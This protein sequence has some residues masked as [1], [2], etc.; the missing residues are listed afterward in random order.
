MNNNLEPLYIYF[1]IPKTGGTTFSWTVGH[2]LHRENDR[3]LKHYSYMDSQNFIHHNIPLL[4]RRT[5]EQQR[6]LKIITG[7]STFSM[8][9]YWLKTRRL[10]RY[11][12]TVRQPID[13]LLS[14]FNYRYGV[15]ELNQNNEIFTKCNPTMSLHACLNL[16]TASDYNSLLE[17]YQ[18]SNAEHNLQCK[19]LLK[20][21]YGIFN[22][23]FFLHEDIKDAPMPDIW[24]AWLDDLIIDDSI[25]EKII[26]IVDNKLWWASTVDTLSTDIKDFTSYA[27][28]EYVDVDNRLRSGVDFPLYWTKEQV[29]AQPDIDKVIHNESYDQMLYD[30]V[31]EKFRRP[32]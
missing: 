5:T 20:S 18:D 10:P 19:W 17:W 32:F 31:K 23:Q 11:I 27:N 7:H 22:N 21:F 25:F 14:S 8:S 26:D 13:R 16:K 6:H 1:H 15:S 30:Y 9:H 28:I 3:W 4:E 29:L 24:P 12:T 2:Y